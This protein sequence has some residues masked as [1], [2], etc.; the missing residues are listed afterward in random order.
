MDPKLLDRFTTGILRQLRIWD[1]WKIRIPINTVGVYSA[2]QR[3][4]K[5]RNEAYDTEVELCGKHK[6]NLSIYAD[7]RSFSPLELKPWNEEDIADL[8]V[9]DLMH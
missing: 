2:V 6:V 3:F 8:P 9:T 5:E 7:P 1:G 4:A